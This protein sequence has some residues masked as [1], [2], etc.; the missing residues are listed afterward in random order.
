MYTRLKTYVTRQE[1]H[2]AKMAVLYIWAVLDIIQ[3]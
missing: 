1:S 2:A 3:I